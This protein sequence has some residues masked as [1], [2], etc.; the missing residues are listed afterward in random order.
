MHPFQNPLKAVK[1]KPLETN[2]NLLPIL[3]KTFK[4]YEL[5]DIVSKRLI[6]AENVNIIL[7]EQN[8]I[9]L[10]PLIS[11]KSKQVSKPFGEFILK[12]EIKVMFF[13]RSDSFIFP[14]HFYSVE[15][16][17]KFKSV[18]VFSRILLGFFVSK[19][20]KN[21]LKTMAFCIFFKNT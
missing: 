4:F 6:M 12:T 1:E 16:I 8:N 9:I 11:L 5:E 21:G 20:L 19:Q 10:C 18:D 2:L 13:F 17:G 7:T 15:E 14:H 3:E